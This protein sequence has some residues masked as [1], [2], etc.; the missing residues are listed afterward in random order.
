LPDKAVDLIDESCSSLRISLENMPPVLEETH[1]KIMLLEIE[2]EA[3]KQE[4]KASSKNKAKTRTKTIDK[5]IANLKEAGIIDPLKVTKTAFL[6]AVSV[7]SNFM[8]VGVAITE[9]PKKD[10]PMPPGGGMPGGMGMGM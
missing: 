9:I 7:A 5:E 8:T 10:E 3:L 4:A 1:R 2:K 6:N